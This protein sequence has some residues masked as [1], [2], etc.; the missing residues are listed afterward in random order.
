MSSMKFRALLALTLVAVRVASPGAIAR[1]SDKVNL[2]SAAQLSDSADGCR[3]LFPK[4]TPPSVTGLSPEWKARWLCSNLF[5]VLYSGLSKTPLLVVERLTRA[6]VLDAE[7]A[8]RTDKFYADPRLPKSERAE[9]KD[10]I[11]TQLDKGHLSPAGDQV[12]EESMA[13]SFALS[14]MVPQPVRNNRKT[15]KKLETDTRKYA[16]RATGAVFV[17]SGPLFKGELRTIGRSQV[18]VPSHLFKFVYDERSGR[19]W[20]HILENTNAAEIG[21]PLSL[22]EF[23]RTAGWKLLSP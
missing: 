19:S 13:Q 15:W 12:D 9:L 17:F 23:E 7:G 10:F 18:W 3:H 22:K 11:G 20:A 16:K 5:V 2:Y 8:E 4:G 1:P 14:N 21:T 6:T